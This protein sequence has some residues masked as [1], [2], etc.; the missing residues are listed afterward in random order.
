MQVTVYRAAYRDGCMQE[1]QILP[2]YIRS[3]YKKHSHERMYMSKF[4][5]KT[6]KQIIFLGMMVLEWTERGHED[7]DRVV[8]GDVN[9]QE[10]L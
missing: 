5:V 8:L 9:A 2:T 10:D 3:Y 1:K 4:M 7:V 6:Q